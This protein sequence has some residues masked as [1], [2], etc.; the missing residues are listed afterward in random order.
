MVLIGGALLVVAT[1]KPEILESTYKSY[2]L[3][4]TSEK[5]GILFSRQKVWEKSYANAEEG[6]WLG[7]GYG[8]TIGDTAFEGGLTAVGYGR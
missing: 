2:I 3:K 4:G 8:V 6:G 5:S 7:A 1:V